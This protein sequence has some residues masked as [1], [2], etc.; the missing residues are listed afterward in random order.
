LE[1]EPPRSAGVVAIIIPY[2]RRPRAA[3]VTLR[4]F[5]SDANQLFYAFNPFIIIINQNQQVIYKNDNIIS[6]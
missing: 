3:R 1:D 6:C 4:N 2:P 5:S